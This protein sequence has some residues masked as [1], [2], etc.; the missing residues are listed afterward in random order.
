[1]RNVD[2]NRIF[3]ITVGNFT[4]HPN[5][6]FSTEDRPENALSDEAKLALTTHGRAM[7]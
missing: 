2:R 7:G 1:M 5:R 4:K 3:F 6:E